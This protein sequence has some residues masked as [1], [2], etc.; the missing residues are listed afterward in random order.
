MI[1]LPYHQFGSELAIDHAPFERF[2]FHVQLVQTAFAV[3]EP[4]VLKR[5]ESIT[6]IGALPPGASCR[7][8][9]AGRSS[10]P[11]QYIQR[12]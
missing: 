7:P 4:I 3:A 10:I 6:V 11:E 2:T 5:I 8:P 1:F 12:R 9:W